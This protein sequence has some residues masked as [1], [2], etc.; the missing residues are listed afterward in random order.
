MSPIE[1]LRLERGW[2]VLDLAQRS[3][4]DRHSIREIERGLLRYGPRATTL[5]RLGDALGVS[6]AEL[7]PGG[8]R[9]A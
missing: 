1:R 5:R 2:T 8:E 3:G 9:G 4:V 6:P 7:V